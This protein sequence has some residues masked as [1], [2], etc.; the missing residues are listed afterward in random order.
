MAAALGFAACSDQNEVVDNL[1]DEVKNRPIVK[2][3]PYT[4]ASTDYN[5]ISTAA[6]K[7][8]GDDAANKALAEA[9]RNTKSLNSFADPLKYI[10]VALAAKFPVLGIESAIQVTYAYTADYLAQLSANPPAP[11]L[12][13]MYVE[14]FDGMETGSLVDGWT[15]FDK[16]GTRQWKVGFYNNAGRSYVEVTS[17]GTPQEKNDVWLVSPTIDL[18]SVSQAVVMFGAQV[19]FP[20]TNHKYLKVWAS[21]DFNAASPQSAT[22]TELTSSFNLPTAQ[23]NDTAPAGAASLNAFTGGNVNIAFEYIGDGTA[24]PALTT[25]FRLDNFSV[26]EGS[27]INP[28]PGE[29]YF[30]DPVVSW[31]LYADGISLT[32]EDY[33]WLGVTSLDATQAPN[34]LPALLAHKFNA[35]QEGTRKAV[36]FGSNRAEYIF[37]NKEWVPSLVGALITEQYVNDGEKWIFDPTINYTMVYT[38]HQMVVDDIRENGIIDYKENKQDGATYIDSYGTSEYYYGFSGY[39]RYNNVNLRIAYRDDYKQDA[40]FHDLSDDEE[41]LALL[42]DRLEHKGMPRFLALKFPLSPA[43]TQGV[44]QHYNINIQIHSPIDGTTNETKLYMMRYK[45]LTAGTAETPATFEHVS[46]TLLD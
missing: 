3:F 24:S 13:D 18:S 19:R 1:I 4:L 36:L 40:E 32:A 12:V 39:S 41:K 5:T 44:A 8:A 42:W 43:I 29:V 27:V 2:S 14:N 16:T 25:T 35:P 20:V 21:K 34:Y 23:S 7:D 28:Q 11:G 37:T 38:D 17:Y 15:Q 46:T 9:V 10:P 33:A 30:N 6:V 26:A 45:V 31:T 22:W